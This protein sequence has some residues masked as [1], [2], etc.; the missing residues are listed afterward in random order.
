M[1]LGTVL[2]FNHAVNYHIRCKRSTNQVKLIKIYFGHNWF[3]RLLTAPT[4][5]KKHEPKSPIR[6]SY[7]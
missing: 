7:K 5:V 3:N 2:R 6:Y 1:I 4:T